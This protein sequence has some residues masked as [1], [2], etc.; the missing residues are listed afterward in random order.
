MI[1]KA[2]LQNYTGLTIDAG[3]E[4]F[5]NTVVSGV[6]KYI[7]KVTGRNFVIPDPDND[8]VRYYDGNDGTKIAIDDLR[9]FTSLVVDGE[10]LVEDEDFILYPLNA[11][12]DGVPY[13]RIELIQPATRINSSSRVISNAPYI[14]EKGQGNIVVTGKFGYADEVP[15]DIKLVAMKLCAGIIKENLGDNDVK[16]VTSESLGEYSVSY[17]KLKDIAGAL[18]V[19]DL[20]LQYVRADKFG[21]STG[22]KTE[23]KFGYR[24]A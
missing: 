2:E 12:A 7:K 1:T 17:V 21:V 24:Q 9:S 5:F 8:E 10:T 6:A 22:G 11:E 19:D 18:E 4:T 3:I 13:E 20:L 14:F 15:D 16:E 23:R